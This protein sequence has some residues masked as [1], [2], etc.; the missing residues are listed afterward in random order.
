V[1]QTKLTCWQFWS[2]RYV[3]HFQL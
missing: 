2:A 3:K 1:R